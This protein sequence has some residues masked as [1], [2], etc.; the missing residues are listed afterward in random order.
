MATIHPSEGPATGT[1]TFSAQ[2]CLQLLESLSEP[3]IALEYDYMR[4]FFPDDPRVADTKAEKIE[5]LRKSLTRTIGEQFR[6]SVENLNILADS[7]TTTLD[8]TKETV[9]DL[10]RKTEDVVDS[11]PATTTTDSHLTAGNLT[12]SLE[13][14]VSVCQDLYFNSTVDD[15]RKF[16]DFST[17][18]PGGR[19]TAYFGA[20]PYSYG[21]LGRSKHSPKPYPNMPL[22]DE[23]F[24][25]LQSHGVTRESH[26]IL[27]TLY[28]NGHVGIPLHQDNES[29]IVKGS[30]IFTIS[31]GATRQLKI[32]NTEGPLKEFVVPLEH[33]SVHA[34]SQESQDLWRHG[35]DKEPAVK[36]ARVSF[37]IRHLTTEVTGSTPNSR[38][39]PPIIPP[40]TQTT[41]RTARVM[42]VTD[43]IHK[44]TPEHVFEQV[45][46]ITC[47]KKEC[48]QLCDIF[49]MEREFEHAKTVILSSGINDLSRYGKTAHTLA[50]LVC[51][52][53]EKCCKKFSK[54]NFIFN[55]ITHVKNNNWLNDE[56]NIFND[57]M[58]ELS[59]KVRNLTYFDSHGLIMNMKPVYV[60]DRSERGNGVHLC[61]DVRRTIVKGMVTAVGKVT[62]AHP[63]KF[64]EC[65]WL[66]NYFNYRPS[67][68]DAVNG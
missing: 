22:F 28:E 24:D 57:F 61:Y 45:P 4:S 51:P 23:I 40:P 55:S 39:I 18:H 9:E 3:Q 2:T 27:C 8:R 33:G 44:S 32:Y 5:G 38:Q 29:N 19:R 12:P 67:Y 34:M 43:S 20:M 64:R 7:I 63:L 17:T 58:F 26:G 16:V 65:R 66:Y 15:I 31:F 14:P 25:K 49:E 21:N 47:V 10:L 62:S 41:S 54:T 68:A 42:L 6:I 56:V 60:W 30:T 35:L 37:T 36:E 1:F 50:D 59:Q 52:K 46:G 13:C 48:Y 11:T 53:L